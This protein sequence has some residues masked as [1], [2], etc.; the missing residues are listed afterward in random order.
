VQPA[1]TIP[2]FDAFLAERGLRLEA[3]IIGGAALNLLGVVQRETRD[4]D[5]LA[6]PLPEEILA[7]A[8]DFARARRAAGDVLRDEWLNNGP[9]MLSRQLPAGWERRAQPLFS[10]R[11]LLLRSLGRADLLK[12]KLF[13]F[14]DR[15]TDLADCLA[16]APTAAELAE[17]LP[18]LEAQDAN[19]QWPEY[20]R[21]MFGE[22]GR[23]L[24]HGV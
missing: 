24:G 1:T 2:A 4:C 17:A 7:A 6:P 15:R 11:A 3:I 22:L 8:R 18:W 10:G 9:E 19:E 13:A 14:C 20:V 23:R 16:L 21:Q 12:T 5:V